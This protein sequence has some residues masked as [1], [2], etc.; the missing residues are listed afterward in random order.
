MEHERLLKQIKGEVFML[1]SFSGHDTFLRTNH[2][3]FL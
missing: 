3:A 2:G 1:E